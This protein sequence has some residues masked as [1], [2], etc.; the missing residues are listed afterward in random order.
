MSNKRVLTNKNYGWFFAPAA[1][2]ADITAI[3][4]AEAAQFKNVTDAAKLDGTN[5]NTKPSLSADDRSFADAAGAKARG[6]GDFGGTFSGFK[7]S[8][9][10]TASSYFEAEAG[11]KP[12]GSEFI[13]LARPVESA[14]APLVAGDEYSAFRVLTDAPSDVRGDSSYSWTADLLP[15]SDMAIRSIIAPAVAASVVVT[16]A[17]GVAS[18]AAGSVTRLKAVYQGTIVTVGCKW[19]T[20]DPS[21]VTVTEHGIVQRVSVGAADVV[22]TFPGA[23][24]SVAT[25]ITVTA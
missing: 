1:A 11:I 10:D 15:Q 16:V 21:V 22:A 6:N 13:L 17:S 24:P 23:T 8:A 3:T 14:S 7:A 20:S 4:A 5:F 9:D 25:A 12:A 2:V 18:G 19:T